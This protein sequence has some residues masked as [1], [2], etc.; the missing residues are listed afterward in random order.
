MISLQIATTLNPRPKLSSFFV[1]I[2]L[3]A[4]LMAT[5]CKQNVPSPKPV[6]PVSSLT[7]T[8]PIPG[9][10]RDVTSEAGIR[11]QLSNGATGNFY[12][13]ESTPGGCAFLDYNRDGLPDVFLVQAGSL[14]QSQGQ[15]PRPH[16][17][18]YRN[19]GGG[20]FTDVTHEAR[21]DF[22]QG[23][24]QGVAIGDFN[25]DGFS[26][27]FITGLNGCF[28]LQ[29]DGAG[30]FLNVTAK[31]GVGETGQNRY[32]TSAAFGDYDGDGFLDLVI[33]H[34]TKWTV[35]TDKVCFNAKNKKSYCSPE[36][37]EP[38]IPT[39]YHNNGDGTFTDV[40]HSAGLD[41]IKGRGLGVT[42]ID[43]NQDGK[44]DLYIANDLM[45]NNLYKN[46]GNGRFEEVGLVSGVAYGADGKTLAG[47]GI[48]VG[49]YTNEGWESLI[50][51]NFSG[52]PNS[53]Y[54][55]TASGLFEDNTYAS[56]IGSVSLPYLAFGVSFLDFDRDGWRDLVVGDG[57]ID[58]NVAESSPNVTYEQPKL[59]FRN[60]GDGKFVSMKDE[61]GDMAHPRVTRGLAV[62]DYDN[63]GRL[64]VLANNVNE[65]VELFHNESHDTNHWIELKLEG[66]KTNRDGAGSL[67]WITAG[68]KRYFA[69]CRLGSSYASSSDSRLFFGLGTTTKVDS[70]EI[71]WLD[72]TRQKFTSPL[73]VDGGYRLREGGQ[74]QADPS[75][76][77]VA[78]NKTDHKKMDHKN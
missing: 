64:D 47:M 17:A 14:V 77:S 22:D 31:A 63:D 34:Y 33:L 28:L 60:T 43:Y 48:A 24:A 25:N 74:P 12:Y 21:L 15:P 38:V 70:L 75:F 56:G 58:P 50:V 9:I 44:E 19:D 42:W 65:S 32:A 40:T 67:V 26:D 7:P 5:G 2:L 69:E 37:Y 8:S 4:F 6:T 1:L 18:L 10:F 72:G 73:N 35:A 20:H 41:K 36:V 53:V 45:P 55:A 71:R 27:I 30:H 59:L 16:C 3:V 78:I 23:Y 39:L 13:A 29:N 62:G 57:H 68:G 54:K 66:V 61:L 11:F 49:D 52:Q 51:T 76:H 46:L